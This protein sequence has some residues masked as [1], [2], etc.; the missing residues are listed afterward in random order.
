MT[1]QNVASLMYDIK[2]KITDKEFKDIMDAL[3]VVH[4]DDKKQDVYLFKYYKMKMDINRMWDGRMGNRLKYKYK[5]IE[6]VLHEDLDDAKINRLM[7]NIKQGID[8]E[9]IIYKK[10]EKNNYP[11][12][13]TAQKSVEDLE[14]IE[15]YETYRDAPDDDKKPVYLEYNEIIPI[16][17]EKL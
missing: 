10:K 13:H 4:K 3:G 6:V 9:F 1:A 8:Y 14:P 5:E 17:I 7:N 15:D 2:E 16:S 11:V 12:L